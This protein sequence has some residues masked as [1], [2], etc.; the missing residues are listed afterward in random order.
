MRIAL[1]L[2]SNLY[3]APYV[4]YYTEILEKCGVPYDIIAWNRFGV[5]EAGVQALNL[6]SSLHK[7]IFGK[8]ID[9]VRYKRFVKS[10]LVEG[11]YDKVVV[12]TIVNA[13]ML[14]PFLKARYR[15]NYVFDIRDY[16]VALKYFRA[17]LSAAI[18]DAALVVISS[19]GFKRWLPKDNTYVIRHNTNV[20]RP[21]DTLVKIKGQTKYKILTIGA[22]GYYDANRA[23]IEHLAD[24]PM[25][26]LEFVGSG[27]AEQMLKDFVAS[28]GIK[29][30]SFLG[31][32]AKEDEPKYL[33]GAAL[34]SI[35]MDDSINSITCMSNRFYLSVVYGIP[36]I[37]NSN[38]EQG[39]C[40]EKYNLGI[41]ID[42]KSDIK[43]QI[44]R[45]LRM[46]D[47][48]I[49]DI[50]R[51]AYLEIVQNDLDEFELKF[52]KFLLNS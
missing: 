29:N 14:F 50:G 17:R 13:L 35:L 3:M 15:N 39:T 6:T 24:S 36:M 23:L 31:R 1:I 5:A 27:Y 10:K 12:F 51:K 38:S 37:V 21:L 48:E 33:Q 25:F 44:I 42:K 4:R 2:A 41:V 16:S 47:N 32:Y 52:K 22:I 9:Y 45:Y 40:A 26:E 18:Q 34:I 30:V 49:F 28:R 46:F 11:N 20:F 8:I 7:S 43:K 19:A